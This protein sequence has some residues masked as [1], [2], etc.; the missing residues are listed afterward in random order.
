[1]KECCRTAAAAFGWSEFRSGLK[2]RRDGARALGYGMA[3]ACYPVYRNTTE[4][5]VS[6]WRDGSASIRCGTQDVGAG[7]YTVLA[8]LVADMLGIPLHRV[9]VELGDTSLP[10]G[11]PSAGAMATAS[12][13]PAVETAAQRVRE[14][15]FASASKD[16][17]SPVRGADPAR[18]SIRDGNIVDAESGRSEPL[19]QQ[20]AR[21]AE[22]IEHS[23]RTAPD[24][25]PAYSGY[26]H[27]AIF[28]EVSVDP[29]LG[30]VR[31]RRI[32]A[33]YASGRILN[34]RLVRGQYIGGL[35]AGIG[36]TLHEAVSTD[37]NLGCVVNDNLCDYLLPVHADI[38]EFDIHLV[39]QT[40]PH[41][42]HGVK[43]VGMI[44]AVGVSAAIANAV[45]DACGRRVRE[46][47]IRLEQTLGYA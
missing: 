5:S 13:V 27:G 28:A 2:P 44:G 1:L 26:S 16:I 22:D 15:L 35:I 46:L 30:E 29:T 19:A 21:L 45:Y 32:S 23:A 18:L 37:R 17:D 39:Q 25:K 36:M 7:T 10:E 43:G 24:A 38:P 42:A 20:L 14:R 6:L 9:R 33:A 3:A 12:F 40:D 4:A 31:V 34:P 47:P 11:P 8:Q 41:L